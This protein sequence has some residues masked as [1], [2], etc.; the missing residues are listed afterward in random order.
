MKYRKKKLR[1]T[2]G[3]GYK[4]LMDKH[5]ALLDEFT[6]TQD[7]I[8]AQMIMNGRLA[9]RRPALKLQSMKIERS[10]EC[11]WKVAGDFH[12]GPKAL[13]KNG[14]IP[15]KYS[16]SVTC[17][18]TLDKRGF[19]FD[20]AMVDKWMQRQAEKETKLSCEALVI[21][22]AERLLAKMARDVPHC[23]VTELILTLSP[24]PH[25]AGVTARFG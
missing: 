8:K 13:V 1:L 22:L 20:Q 12:C 23:K 2:K 4:Q 19:L 18:P 11:N 17:E 24:A 9:A 5:S 6:L 16:M 7:Q 25:Q 10:G 14:L 15:V 3:K 21:D